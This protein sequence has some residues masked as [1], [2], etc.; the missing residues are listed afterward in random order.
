VT[1]PVSD[2]EAA[3]DS[4]SS[5]FA[6]LPLGGEGSMVCE[7]DVCFVPGSDEA[8]TDAAGSPASA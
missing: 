6:L 5:P 4:A 3:R 7:G 2:L 8:A 1:E